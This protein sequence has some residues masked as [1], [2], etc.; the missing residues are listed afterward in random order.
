MATEI[1][2]NKNNMKVYYM[3]MAVYE[4]QSHG[5]ASVI[6]VVGNCCTK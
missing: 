4:P 2:T 1:H 5:L 6:S 3:L